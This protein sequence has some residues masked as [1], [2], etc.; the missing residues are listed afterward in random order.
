MKVKLIY[1]GNE[2]TEIK[3]VDLPQIPRKGDGFCIL[4]D[5][6]QKREY[7]SCVVDSVDWWVENGKFEK[8]EI[9]LIDEN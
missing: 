9:Y 6:K 3:E 7:A 2:K 1:N 4:I 8:V 5:N